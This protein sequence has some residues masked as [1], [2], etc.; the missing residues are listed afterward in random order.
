MHDE[1]SQ[2]PHPVATFSKSRDK[3]GVATAD[4]SCL[5]RRVSVRS[6]RRKDITDFLYCEQ[7]GEN[8]VRTLF[9]AVRT[10]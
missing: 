1:T 4:S 5:A 2:N 7:V 6:A 10:Q 8:D 9:A 3:G